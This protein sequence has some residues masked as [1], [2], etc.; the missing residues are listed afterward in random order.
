MEMKGRDDMKNTI[1]RQTKKTCQNISMDYVL[2]QNM[3]RYGITVT[4]EDSGESGTVSD[5]S[6]IRDVSEAFFELILGG[7]VTPITL[8]DVAEDFVVVH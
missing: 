5:I 3:E 4:N 6:S 1:I 8:R 7:F 2:F